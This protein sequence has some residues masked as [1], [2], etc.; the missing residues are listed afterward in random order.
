LVVS[1][2]LAGPALSDEY[3][4]SLWAEADHLA[5]GD[6]VKYHGILSRRAALLFQQRASIGLVPYLPLPS[7]MASL[8]IKLV[9]CMALGLPVV[10]SDFPNYREV[11]GSSGA[12]I[13]V[14]P[15]RPEEIADAIERLVRNP[16]LA[17]HMGE[18]GRRAVR[19]RFNWS[20]ELA[21]LLELYQEIL[22]PVDRSGRSE[23][24]QA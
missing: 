9:E 1:L 4:R 7:H 14:D 20:V 16:N 21:K 18:A 17:Q 3:L 13:P 8:A 24:V 10:F 11:A 22:G 5:V 2:D 12:G 23:F 6:L 19:D 15:T